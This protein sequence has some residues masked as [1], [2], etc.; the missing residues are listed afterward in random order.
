M[1]NV[2]Y[3]FIAISFSLNIVCKNIVCNAGLNEITLDY[4]ESNIIDRMLTIIGYFYLVIYS[5]WDILTCDHIKQL[6]KL[7]GDYIKR[8]SL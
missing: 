6:I 5:K 2:F 4:T 3:H 1:K 8:L 7:T